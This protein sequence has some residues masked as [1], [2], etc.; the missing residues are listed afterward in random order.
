MLTLAVP[1]FAFLGFIGANRV[2]AANESMY[3]SMLQ[4]GARVPEQKPVMQGSDRW[5]AI[6]VGATVAIITGFILYLFWASSTGNL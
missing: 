4:S 5:P 3:Q 1:A 2:F 6:M